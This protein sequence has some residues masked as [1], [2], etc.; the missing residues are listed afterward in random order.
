M[1]DAQKSK[2]LTSFIIMRSTYDSEARA[3]TLE[4]GQTVLVRDEKQ[5]CAGSEL[6][7]YFF[8]YLQKH[9]R[10]GQ[11][12]SICKKFVV[13]TSSGLETLYTREGENKVILEII[14]IISNRYPC[15]HKFISRRLGPDY[16][17]KYTL[18]SSFDA[19]SQDSRLIEK[20]A[21]KYR[22]PD[23]VRRTRLLPD[24]RQNA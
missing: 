11:Y 19:I 21:D 3:L 12:I 10:S 1:A 18:Q 4:L 15:T 13:L 22:I 5:L 14:G 20:T 24:C 7:T 8:F 2:N 17:M 6:P 23:E 9:A 16:V